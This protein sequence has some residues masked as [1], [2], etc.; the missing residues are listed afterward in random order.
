[1]SGIPRRSAVRYE[2]IL[3]ALKA[4][5]T[6]YA[7]T[8]PDLFPLVFSD[9]TE[10]GIQFLRCMSKANFMQCMTKYTS[11]MQCMAMLNREKNIG[12][13][14]A[15]L[16]RF[17]T[18]TFTHHATDLLEG[19]LL[20]EFLVTNLQ[21]NDQFYRYIDLQSIFLYKPLVLCQLRTKLSKNQQFLTRTFD[22][23]QFV[24]VINIARQQNI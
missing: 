8:N 18:K 12:C 17:Y 6:S 19:L 4:D 22:V 15:C 13:M 7:E 10:H 5:E 2:N 16:P 1:M 9:S 14:C 3:K 21:V 24:S 20:Y 23:Y 11:F